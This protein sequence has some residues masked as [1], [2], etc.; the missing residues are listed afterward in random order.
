MVLR[1]AH[2]NPRRVLA[3][4]LSGTAA[5]CAQTRA[6]TVDEALVAMA[7]LLTG[8]GVRPGTDAAVKA[9]TMAAEGY[10]A[11]DPPEIGQWYY[12]DALAVLVQAGAD[13]EAARQAR[14]SRPRRG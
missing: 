1:V 14:R 8:A 12:P 4:Q 13:E 11:D 3:A 10:I 2:Y 6:I 5:R 9:L 7:A